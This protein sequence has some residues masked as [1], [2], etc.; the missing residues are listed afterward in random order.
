MDGGM[1]LPIFLGCR[2]ELVHGNEYHDPGDNSKRQAEEHRGNEGPENALPNESF[3]RFRH[4]GQ[5]GEQERLPFASRRIVNGN[6]YGDAL[7]NVMQG[8]MATAM[9]MAMEGSV[10]ADMNVAMPSGK[11]WMAMADTENLPILRSS[12]SLRALL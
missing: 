7:G 4:S 1:A 12:S 2:K 8:T 6:G 3:A 11:F 9:G 10:R 5:E